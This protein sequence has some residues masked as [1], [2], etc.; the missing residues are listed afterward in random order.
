M[1]RPPADEYRARLEARGATHA[2]LSATDLRFSQARLGVF[3]LL[4]LAAVFA[5]LDVVSAFW[6]ILPVVG[7]AVLIQRHDRVIRARDATARAIAFY[8]RGLA[9][10]EDRWIGTGS[11]GE[12]FADDHHLYAND[13]DLFGRGSLFELLSIARTRAGE[14]TL[15]AWLKTPG[16]RPEVIERQHAI[17]ELTASL[18]FR[19]SIA[20]LGTDAASI[21]SDWLMEWGEG[22]AVLSPRWFRQ[23]A[24]AIT[25][26]FIVIP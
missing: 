25:A 3:G 5:W 4:V 7:L 1:P 26:A 16:A 8:E 17:A 6:L 12:R 23:L 2:V 20:T 24:W 18:D 22:A 21:R 14:D 9:R 19:E 11:S 15:A 13:L 10:I